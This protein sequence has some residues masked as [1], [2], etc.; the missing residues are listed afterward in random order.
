MTTVDPFV[1]GD[2]LATVKPIAKLASSGGLTRAR[3]DVCS[4]SSY[5]YTYCTLLGSSDYN[6]TSYVETKINYASADRLHNHSMICIT[7]PLCIIS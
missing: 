6:L 1:Y 2:E 3:D 5:R 7:I 4:F